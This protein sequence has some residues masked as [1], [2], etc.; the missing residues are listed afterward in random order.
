MRGRIFQG[1]RA[2]E[3]AELVAGS[4]ISEDVLN[5]WGEQYGIK[6]LYVNPEDLF[7]DPEIDIVDVCTPNNYHAPL[8]IGAL[9]AG[10][11]VICEKPLAPSPKLV[12]DMIAARDS[13]GK[14]LMCAQSSR[15]AGAS[16]A[17]KKELDTGVLGNVYHARCWMLRRSGGARATGFYYE[18]A[19]WWRAVY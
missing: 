6:K 11:H 13:S 19:Q 7:A 12:K 10:K 16:L 18:K 8:S 1:W 2:S 3:H 17:M 5:T 15:F 4:D 14:L 9:D